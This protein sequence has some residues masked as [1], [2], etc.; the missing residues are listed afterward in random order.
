MKWPTGWTWLPSEWKWSA[1]T[2]AD[3]LLLMLSLSVLLH[4]P[5]FFRLALEGKPSGT[6]HSLTVSLQSAAPAKPDRVQPDQTKPFTPKQ[7]EPVALPPS[8][9]PKA[10]VNPLPLPAAR[11]ASSPVADAPK[12]ASAPSA[13][14]PPGTASMPLSELADGEGPENS[15]GMQF[16]LDFYYAARQLDVLALEQAPIQL[17]EPYG[18]SLDDVDITL[19]VYINETGGV[20]AVQV[21]SA[22]PAG[23]E[24]PLLPFFQQARFYPAIRQGRPVKSYKVIHIGLE[25]DSEADPLQPGQIPASAGK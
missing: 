10:A 7:P 3:R 21:A 22:R 24:Q 8:S 6:G 16:G 13:N 25:P 11:D 9:L 17:L 4:A 12:P 18:L 14:L 23:A 2:D 20:D 5:L 19:R 15:A 1:L